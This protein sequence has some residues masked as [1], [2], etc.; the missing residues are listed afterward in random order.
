MVL[1]AMAAPRKVQVWSKKD[2]GRGRT[3]LESFLPL[4][5]KNSATTGMFLVSF[6]EPIHRE[7]YLAVPGHRFPARVLIQ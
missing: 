1:D 5:N 7:F 3:M 2:D 6:E 4:M